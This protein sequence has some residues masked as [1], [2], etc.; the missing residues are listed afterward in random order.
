MEDL[1]VLRLAR[2]SDK[3][4]CQTSQAVRQA[5][6]SDKPGK[7]SWKF[8]IPRPGYPG[9]NKSPAWLA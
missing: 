7:Y 1:A 4:G 3:P 2:L 9:R 6:L 8:K 5:R